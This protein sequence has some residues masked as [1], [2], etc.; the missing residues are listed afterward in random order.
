MLSFL[1][2]SRDSLSLS[3]YIY[4]AIDV[5]MGNITRENK[6]NLSSC[7]RVIIGQAR[8]RRDVRWA[9]SRISIERTRTQRVISIICVCMCVCVC[10][11]TPSAS[12]YICEWW[13]TEIKKALENQLFWPLCERAFVSFIFSRVKNCDT[14]T[15]FFTVCGGNCRAHK[16]HIKHEQWWNEVWDFC[17]SRWHSSSFF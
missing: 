16:A 7:S 12:C 14:A 13:G 2:W 15:R 4:I 11:F 5:V 6:K 1:P 3:I 10:V 8:A 17:F 9:M